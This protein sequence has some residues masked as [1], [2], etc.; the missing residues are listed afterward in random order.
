VMLINNDKG[1]KN[2]KA[3]DCFNDVIDFRGF[4]TGIDGQWYEG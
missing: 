3:R 2:E 1:E 4:R